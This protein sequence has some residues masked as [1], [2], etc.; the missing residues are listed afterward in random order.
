M[1]ARRDVSTVIGNNGIA[2]LYR[3]LICFFQGFWLLHVSARRIQCI[4]C[5]YE[6]GPVCPVA[7]LY[8]CNEI[9][10]SLSNNRKS[11]TFTIDSQLP[12]CKI[13]AIILVNNR[14]EVQA[15]RNQ[16]FFAELVLYFQMLQCNEY[17]I[18]ML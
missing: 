14:N 4:G 1:Y 12:S 11:I 8:Y 3:N 2:L 10:H 18:R 17:T 5:L 7:A 15:I 6:T 16:L 9:L 13:V